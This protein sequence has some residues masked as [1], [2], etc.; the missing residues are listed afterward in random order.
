MNATMMTVN[1]F[2]ENMY[3]L[4]DET[5]HEAVVV[6]PGMMRQDER[7]MV[8]KFIAD[9]GL[10]VKHI[11]L[12]HLHLDHVTSARWLADQTGAFQA[13]IQ[14]KPNQIPTWRRLAA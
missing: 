12:T 6:D 11:L 8:T 3:I 5:S 2:G 7:D 1:P 13:C 10:K 9:N 4:W 14:Q